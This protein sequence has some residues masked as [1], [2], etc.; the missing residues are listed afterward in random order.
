MRVFI[1][2]PMSGIEHNNRAAFEEAALKLT[3]EGNDVVDPSEVIDMTT[4]WS[5]EEGLDIDLYLLGK[6]DAIY[7]LQ[8]WQQSC[9]ANREYGYAVG[10]DMYIR[11]EANEVKP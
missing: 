10:C 5:R 8:G 2:G 4:D 11:E 3:K 7:M 9:G 1:S 6:C